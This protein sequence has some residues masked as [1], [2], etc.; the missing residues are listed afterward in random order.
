MD[1]STVKCEVGLEQVTFIRLMTGNSEP[2]GFG[3]IGFLVDDVYVFCDAL[4]KVN[5]RCG[6]CF[7]ARVA[8]WYWIIAIIADGSARPVGGD[9]LHP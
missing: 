7:G 4:E 3:H 8:G 6:F 2:R 5:T 9:M 1:G